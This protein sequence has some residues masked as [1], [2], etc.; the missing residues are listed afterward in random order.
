MKGTVV[1][2][3]MRETWEHREEDIDIFECKRRGIPVLGTNE[4][5]PE[6]DTFSY[7]GPLAIKLAMELDIEII[8]SNI[9]VIGGGIFGESAVRA[10]DKLGANIFNINVNKGEKPIYTKDNKFFIR[11]GNSTIQLGINEIYAYIKNS[12][13]I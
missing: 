7:I 11:S 1:I 10:F 13:E 4:H 2:P 9:V 5:I 3:L 8:H 6:V 12:F